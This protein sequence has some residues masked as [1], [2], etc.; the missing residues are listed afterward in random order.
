MVFQGYALYPNMSVEKYLAFGPLVRGDNE[1]DIPR[2]KRE[3]A[4]ILRIEDLL[5]RKP[6]ELSGGQRQRVALGRSSDQ[7]TAGL[8]AR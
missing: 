4:A 2:R 1:R 6:S 3:T 8:P 7:T 5:R